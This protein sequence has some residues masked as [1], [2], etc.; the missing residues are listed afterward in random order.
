MAS[1]ISVTPGQTIAKGD[2]QALSDQ[3]GGTQS[4]VVIPMPAAPKQIAMLE[5]P[6]LF[7]PE[8]NEYS[9]TYRYYFKDGSYVEA[10]TAAD[11]QDYEITN[12]K[13]SQKFVNENPD[14]VGRG[15]TEK[16]AT[17]PPTRPK[18]EDPNTYQTWNPRANN[19]QGAWED[20]GPIAQ[21][22]SDAAK[23]PTERVNP[24]DPTKRQ[25]WNPQA[26]GGQGAWEESGDVA[27][28]KE[29]RHA[30]GVRYEGTTKVTTYS[31]GTETREEAAPKQQESVTEAGVTY[32][33][34]RDA[35]GNIVSKEVVPVIGGNRL[36][37]PPGAPPIDSTPGNTAQS[38]VAYSQWLNGK[39]LSGE[40]DPATATGLIT[41][42]RAEAET[43]INERSAAERAASSSRTQ[44]ITQRGQDTVTTQGRLSAANS[45]FN[46]IL[47]SVMPLLTQLPKGSEAGAMVLTGLLKLFKENAEQLGGLRDSPSVGYSKF[48][49]PYAPPG[50]SS[51]GTAP[52]S[53]PVMPPPPPPPIPGATGSPAHQSASVG[54]Q[55]VAGSQTVPAPPPAIGNSS[56][57][58]S[59][60]PT[61]AAAL[62]GLPTFDPRELVNL[63]TRGPGQSTGPP[64][65]V[66]APGAPEGAGALPSTF[67]DT[68][69]MLQQL[70]FSP[71]VLAEA[72]RQFLAGQVAA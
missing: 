25:V 52:A 23:P 20:S 34:T 50:A 44:D 53:M 70:G 58:A 54:A 13:P 1:Q 67:G 49:Q 17:P 40:I 60:L 32:K 8:G 11:G 38:L 12:Y 48:Q 62:R 56:T 14:V 66:A 10:R 29:A 51:T 61:G 46:Q 47:T 5:H 36:A 45:G 72:R 30:T 26:N 33:I 18:P 6:E 41:Q 69:T 43:L 19:G 9:P 7:D 63:I 71:E 3:H 55:P 16:A 42:K 64:T 57:G 27:P 4:T 35:Q 65:A 15:T 59:A 2:W 68:E 22:P 24:A 39:V 31:D 21:K 37:E 28:A